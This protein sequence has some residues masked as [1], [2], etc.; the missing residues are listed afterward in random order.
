MSFFFVFFAV[1]VIGISLVI[2]CFKLVCPCWFFISICQ[3]Y[4]DCEFQVD[5]SRCLTWGYCPSQSAL[6]A[7]WL[8]F[9]TGGSMAELGSHHC[10]V[11]GRDHQRQAAS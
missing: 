6:L 4:L 11:L 5:F 10:V 9:D 7:F 1:P 3:N 2:R 8:F